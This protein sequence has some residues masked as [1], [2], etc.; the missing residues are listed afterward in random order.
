MEELRVT[1]ARDRKR[2]QA[3]RGLSL[4]ISSGEIVAVVGESGSGKSALGLALLGLLP[5]EAEVQGSAYV[6][7]TDMA[8]APDCARRLVRRD[9]LG[10]V[11]Q[12]P[13]TSL[14]PL[15]RVGRQLVEATGSVEEATRLLEVMGIPD[16]SRR[17]RSYPHELS[18]GQRQRVMIAMAIAGRPKLVVADEP[19]TALDVTVQA[20]ILRRLAQLRDDLGTSFL[21]I[22]HDLGV[23]G[24][25]ADRI[26]VLYGGRIVESGPA[27]EILEAPCHPYTRSL[28][29]SRLSLDLGAATLPSVDPSPVPAVDSRIDAAGCLFACRCRQAT[30]RCLTEVP[31]I[32]ENGAGRWLACFNPGARAGDGATT[33]APPSREHDHGA[34]KSRQVPARDTNG[35][36]VLDVRSV[37][38]EFNTKSG[39]LAALRGVDLSVSAGESV[40]IVGESGCGKST[41]LRVVAGL[42]AATAGSVRLPEETAP[43]M[44]FQDPGASLT[45]WLTVGEL[46]E[47]RLRSSGLGREARR[48]QVRRSLERVGL[49]GEVAR[50]RARQL[51]GGQRQRVALARATIVAPSLLLCDEPTSALDAS[52]AVTVLGL[53]GKLRKELGMAMLFVTHD[54]AVARTVADR[55]VVM[56]L[57]RV[58]EEGPA[59]EVIGLPRHPYTRALVDSVPSFAS[60]PPP[61]T[62]EPANPLAIPPGCEFRPRCDRSDD[63]CSEAPLLVSSESPNRVACW[64]PS[65]DRLLAG[66]DSGGS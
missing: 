33:S 61:L 55:L 56:Y 17:F 1:F 28:V 57:G 27:V 6:C 21:F 39:R 38:C 47:E 43:Q 53:L 19:T 31:E 7:G 41:L 51:S 25:L 11:F 30:N 49:H 42:T 2:V 59:D 58:V 10:A 32:S 63:R 60:L 24:C 15:M 3:L 8:K 34:S 44:V 23:A 14:N 66:V 62:G 20:Q 12:D 18:G 26:V 36:V 35:P 16:P 37:R 40:T 13:M 9:H 4:E 48:D 45:P 64:A 50:V 54:L 5:S 29:E 46:L 65:G 22:T 52:L